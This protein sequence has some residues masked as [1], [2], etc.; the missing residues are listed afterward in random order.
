MKPK[1]RLLCILI[2]IKKKDIRD[3]RQPWV[4]N[5]KMG[6]VREYSVTHG[7]N[8]IGRRTR[9]S[10]LVTIPD[11]WVYSTRLV[12]GEVKPLLRVYFLIF[13]VPG[14]WVCLERGIWTLTWQLFVNVHIFYQK[15][16][17]GKRVV[18]SVVSCIHFTY[19]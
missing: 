11:L 17:R 5:R 7:Y 10:L 16:L 1:Y 19:N 14:T 8:P 3:L 18:I 4:T 9:H 6:W 12:V 2:H 15:M 13:P